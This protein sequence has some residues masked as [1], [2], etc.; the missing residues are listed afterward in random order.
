[1]TEGKVT[2]F[3][4]ADGRIELS[5]DHRGT[6]RFVDLE[7]AMKG[8]DPYFGKPARS[9]PTYVVLTALKRVAEDL[10]KAHTDIKGLRDR[11]VRV[12]LTDEIAKELKNYIKDIKYV[13]PPHG[14][15]IDTDILDIDPDADDKLA[16]KAAEHLNQVY[17]NFYNKTFADIAA[18]ADMVEERIPN[19]RAAWLLQWGGVGK[20]SFKGPMS[21]LSKEA[22]ELIDKARFS[23]KPLKLK[24]DYVD[25][26][27]LACE[28]TRYFNDDPRFF[29]H[30]VNEGVSLSDIA[31]AANSE[32][33]SAYSED[34]FLA[35]TEDMGFFDDIE[36][37]EEV[38]KELYAKRGMNSFGPRKSKL[39]EATELH[40]L[41]NEYD[42]GYPTEKPELPE[43]DE[44]SDSHLKLCPECGKETFDIE[45]G[46][47][48]DCGFN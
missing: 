35:G 6:T 20:I 1:M 23:D 45:T 47:C 12:T 26:Y 10:N 48:V 14:D 4:I 29:E 44:D 28:L 25:C 36:T 39:G 8:E 11:V 43:F 22:Q 2:D 37:P 24:N 33:G 34:D 30:T 42:G 21:A 31:A 3:I 32:F 5:Y 9:M 27:R 46:I 17:N 18:A 38:G 19:E 15:Y 40:D 13:I 16:E 41:G 7:A